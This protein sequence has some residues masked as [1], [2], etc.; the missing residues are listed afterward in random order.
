[1]KTPKELAVEHREDLQLQ[2]LVEFGAEDDDGAPAS[3]IC[4]QPA[5]E[6]QLEDAFL[7]GYEAGLKVN[8][9]ETINRIKSKI[10]EAEERMRRTATEFMYFDGV[11]EEG[12]K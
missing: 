3:I 11:I 4:D 7:A 9:P 5:Y 2:D 1:M 8:T 10:K 12:K 6:K